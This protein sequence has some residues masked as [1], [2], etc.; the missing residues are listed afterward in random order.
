[1]SQAILSR[2]GVLNGVTDGSWEQDNAN[3]LKVFTGEVLT[4]FNETNV[5]KN[6]HLERTIQHGK[7]ASFPAIGK[8]KARYHKPGT[9][10]L[11]S[12]K[13][14]H[15]E[16]LIHIDDL[17]IADLFL[18][19]LDDAKN[20]FD[21]RGMY[22]KELGDAMARAY[23]KR[24]LQ[25]VVLA[26]RSGPA[27]TGL[28]GG[29]VLT[30]AAFATDSDALVAAAFTCAQTLDEKDIPEND[31]HMVL[32][33][34]QYYLLC[35]NTKVLNKDWDGSGSFSKG[36]CPEIAGLSL[37]KSNNVPKENVTATE[38][39]RNVYHGDFSKTVASC[40]HRTAIGT[41]K[42]KDLVVQKSGGDVEI[43]YQ[44]TLMVARYAMGHGILR[45][46]CAIE[47]SKGA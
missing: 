25:T 13:I 38:G 43:M 46:E 14:P 7:S 44:G 47:L 11:G 6:L 15:G 4:A 19:D 30:N 9:A 40:F 29:S 27:V 17:L 2:P 21:V 28:P 39:E 18:D 3:F 24:T 23:D 34:A 26:A 37:V 20:H 42:L 35:Q 41:V 31:R 10:I 8:A 22:S 1:M 12:N 32:L 36:K 33:P 45:S 16:R 5:M